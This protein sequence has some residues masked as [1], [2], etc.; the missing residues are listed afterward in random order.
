MVDVIC[1]F[2][3][4]RV[5]GLFFSRIHDR[6]YYGCIPNVLHSFEGIHP[7]HLIP[8]DIPAKVLC[9]DFP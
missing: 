1:S 3:R 7:C 2:A 6:M 8:W 9:F 5:V 4:T